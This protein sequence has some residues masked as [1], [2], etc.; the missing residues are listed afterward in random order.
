MYY[1]EVKYRVSHYVIKTKYV[2]SEIGSTAA[3][4]KTRLNPD[5]IISVK[6]ITEQEY[7]RAKARKAN[8]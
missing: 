8:T 7:K 2:K 4:R 1:Y 3:A 5:K 6:E